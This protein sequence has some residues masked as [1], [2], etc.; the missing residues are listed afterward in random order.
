MFPGDWAK[1]L[2]RTKNRAK[3]YEP[4]VILLGDMNVPTISSVDPVYGAL[5]R[6]GFVRTR[7]S[8]EVGTT[9]QDFTKYDQVVFA[10]DNILVTEIGGQ[11]A[12]LV[13]YDNFMFRDMWDQVEAGERTLTQFKAWAKCSISDHRPV[14]VQIQ[15]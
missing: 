5:S 9:I 14:F 12:V 7:Y 2:Q 6:R 8:S 1:E 10:N 11:T 3:V 15:Q 4:N 13:D